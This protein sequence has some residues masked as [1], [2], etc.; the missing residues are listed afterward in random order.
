MAQRSE[1][2]WYRGAVTDGFE[3]QVTVYEENGDRW[4]NRIW[5]LIPVKVEGGSSENLSSSSLPAYDGEA[6][7]QS[8]ARAQHA[9]YERDDFGTVV[10]EVTTSTITTRKRYRVQDV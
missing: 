1:V 3:I 4:P 10:T 8:S 5:I 9:E 6:T 2:R 7:G